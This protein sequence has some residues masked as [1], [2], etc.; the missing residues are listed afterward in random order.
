MIITVII[1]ITI[2]IMITIMILILIITIKI[3]FQPT[4]KRKL[5][6]KT[7]RKKTHDEFRITS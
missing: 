4:L 1:T 3:K 6:K 5:A 2:M 7:Q